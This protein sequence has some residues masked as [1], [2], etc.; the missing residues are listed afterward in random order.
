MT[1]KV[2]ASNP[3]IEANLDR[4]A[5]TRGPIVY[6]AER[7]LNSDIPLNNLYVKLPLEYGLEFCDKM[8][9]YKMTVKG[10]KDCPKDRIYLKQSELKTEKNEISLLPYFAFANHG[11]SDML[12]WLRHKEEN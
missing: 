5:I 2:I 10:Y 6:C 8:N 1:P 3:E 4:V 9:S 7:V 11:E 12:V